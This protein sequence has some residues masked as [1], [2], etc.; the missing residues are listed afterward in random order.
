MVNLILKIILVGAAVTYVLELIDAILQ[1]FFD[2]ST[3][4]KW[5]SLPLSIGGMWVMQQVWTV[6]L[7]VTVPASTLVSLVILKYINKP[8]QVQYQ[9][10]PRL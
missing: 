4:R 10:L 1:G 8:T 3:I 2:S 5:L 7:F 9:R 6:E